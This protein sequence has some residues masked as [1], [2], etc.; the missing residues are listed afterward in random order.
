MLALLRE[1]WALVAWSLFAIDVIVRLALSVR[2]IFKRAPV[3]DTVTW[4]LVLLL[5]PVLSWVL[6]AFVGGNRLGSLR[7]KRYE[8]LTRPIEDRAAQMWQHVEVEPAMDTEYAPLA[9]LATNVSGFPTLRGNKLE[10]IANADAF[11]KSLVRDI[12]GATHHVHL[13]YYIWD[14]DAKGE[15]VAEAV[16]RAAQRGVACRVLVD[17][18]G[19][20]TLL[21]SE[22]WERMKRAGV[23]CTEALPANLWR[24]LLERVDLRNHRKV[25]VIDGR[26]A[27]CGGQNVTAMNFKSGVAAGLTG[28]RGPWI[29]ATVRMTG[30]AV[31][32]LQISFLRDW[33]MD[34]DEVLD[35]AAALFP[36]PAA[37]GTSIVHVIPS[38]PGPRPDAIHQAFL[39]MLFAARK[40]IVMTTPYFV[41][42]E[43]TKTAIL[44]AALR[45]VTITLNVPRVTDTTLVGAAGRSYFEELLEAG[46]TIFRHGQGLLHVKAMTVDQRISMIGSA[47]FD[48]RSFWLNFESTLFVHDVDFTEQ[49]RTLQLGFIADSRQVMLESWKRRSRLAKFR[50]NAARLFGPL[51]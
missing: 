44:N 22:L 13:C 11:L 45:G 14:P 21:K 35:E 26:T 9:A 6:Y 46:V 8:N 39:A 49:L 10:L 37:P 47:N 16:I 23:R 19:S 7:I 18:V 43:A 27:Y 25:A 36:R 20:S 30:P 41:P 29:D 3:A 15:F 1:H 48:V 50:D 31:Q 12:D 51:L 32:P 2:V 24:A 28:S 38:G 5:M 42:D 4:L 40:E 33:A 34:S 17:S